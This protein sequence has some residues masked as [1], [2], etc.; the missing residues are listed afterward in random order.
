M[1][2]RQETWRRCV[3]VARLAP[4]KHNSQ[5]W[6]FCLTPGGLELHADGARAMPTSDPFGRE[7]MIGCGAALHHLGLA[8]RGEGL[9]PVTVL[10]PEGPEQSLVA[11]VSAT[12]GR[13]PTAAELE[14]LTAATERHTNRGPLDGRLLADAVPF[15][16][17]QSAERQGAKLHLVTT[18]GGRRALDDLVTRADRLATRDDAMVAELGAWVRAPGSPADDGVPATSAA[19][20]HS[21]AYRGVFVQRDFDPRGLTARAGPDDRDEPAVAVL[22]TD[23]DRPLDWVTAGSA[24]SDV[25]LTLTAHLGSASMLN[26]PVEIPSLRS[27]VAT[28]FGLRGFPQL[29]LRLGVGRPVSPTP[30]RS[31]EDLLTTD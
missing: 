1:E 29:I 20:G 12:A 10:F 13:E 21:A 27:S 19:P 8:L 17:Q 15:L 2:L 18:E 5:P 3:G 23:G 4:S 16:L 24:L 26:Q 6:W 31:V 22:W 30:R 14:L 7:V 11:R 28:E 9:D 25:L